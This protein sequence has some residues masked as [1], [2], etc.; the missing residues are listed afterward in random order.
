[1][2]LKAFNTLVLLFIICICNAQSDTLTQVTL[3]TSANDIQI[4]NSIP[5]SQLQISIDTILIAPPEKELSQTE[6]DSLVLLYDQKQEASDLANDSLLDVRE[7]LKKDSIFDM[8]TL[9]IEDLTEDTIDDLVKEES[10]LK[11][12]TTVYFEAVEDSEFVITEVDTLVE[13]PSI[14]ITEEL[15]IV[16]KPKFKREKTYLILNILDSTNNRPIKARVRMTLVNEGARNYTGAGSCNEKGV[17]KM[18]LSHTT[19]FILYAG[20]TEYT[21]RIDTF[22]LEQFENDTVEITVKL[23]KLEVGK[24]IRLS[25]VNFKQGSHQLLTTSYPVLNNLVDLMNNNPK[26][27]IQLEGHTDNSGSKNASI[28]LSEERVNSVRFYL[29][30]KG[31]KSS[32]IKGVGYGS[33]RPI[34]HGSDDYSRRINRRVEFEIL[35]I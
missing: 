30:Q 34:E 20:F 17:F 32:R 6:I 33:S 3:D 5:D 9:V 1:M 31:I 18:K 24:V 21:P 22:N 26:M 27:I 8:D 4:I 11:N 14:I 16:E 19:K 15:E 23:L 25:G 2:W 12:D 13:L 29:I 7:T 10:I 35:K 28:R